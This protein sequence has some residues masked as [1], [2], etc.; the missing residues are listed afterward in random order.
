[1]K[2]EISKINLFSTY[3]ISGSA[4]SWILPSGVLIFAD[5]GAAISEDATHADN[6]IEVL[7]RAVSADNDG[8]HS[9]GAST[10][11]F[12][13]AQGSAVGLLA[14]VRTMGA[15]QSVT[16]YGTIDGRGVGIQN[17]GEAAL[18]DNKGA[19]GGEVGI[20][21]KDFGGTVLNSLEGVISG[22]VAIQTATLDGELVKVKNLGLVTGPIAYSG[23]G[24]GRDILI[25]KGTVSGDVVLGGGDD[26]FDTRSGIFTDKAVG[27]AGNDTYWVATQNVKIVEAGDAD[28]QDVVNSTVSYRLGTGLEQ[29]HLLGQG[30]LGGTGNGLANALY[31]NDGNN[32]LL[33]N[34]GNDR[35]IG[36]RGDDRLTGGKDTDTFVFATGSGHDTITDYVG[37]TD[38]IDFSDMEGIT[39][40]AD[41]KRDHLSV[42]NGSV[43]ITDGADQITLLGVDKAELVKA[44]FDF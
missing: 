8:V 13:D 24:E 14:G 32:T 16:N 31:G 44:M 36:G 39:G 1:M 7:G 34:A 43:I 42:I 25:N 10:D 9:E 4:S 22:T 19:I 35:L 12:V 17:E 28:S 20:G 37:N 11:I 40:F 33:G 23:E 15:S 18:I 21:F 26:V 27:G 29:L 3:E 2:T 6:R 38:R 5:T 41:M 30:N